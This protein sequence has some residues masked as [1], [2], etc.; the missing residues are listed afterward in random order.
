MKVDVQ[1]VGSVSLNFSK[2]R[3]EECRW[4]VKKNDPQKKVYQI[5]LTCVI[6]PGNEDGTLHFTVEWEGKPCGDAVMQFE[7]D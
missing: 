4:T 3:L 2:V 1:L 7:G 5:N 6:K